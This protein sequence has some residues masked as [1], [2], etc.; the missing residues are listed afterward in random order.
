MLRI[1]KTQMKKEMKGLYPAPVPQRKE[2]FLKE[3]SCSGMG[4]PEIIRVQ[5]GYIHKSVWALS[6]LLVIGALVWGEHF[7]GGGSYD[8]LWCMS[9]VMPLLAV[10]VVTE[11]FRSGIYGMAELEMTARHNLP[12]ILLIRMGAIGGAE[13]FLTVLGIPFVVRQGTLGVF[14]TAVYLMVPWLCT[15]VLTLQIEKYVKGRETVW[16]CAACGFFLWGAGIMSGE[17]REMIYANGKF[18]LWI[19][20]FCVFAAFFA[21]QIWQIRHRT[22][23]WNLYFVLMEE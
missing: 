7:H 15:C 21:K 16:Y 14:R 2:E 6:L 5:V 10:L 23:E 13:F 12:Q 9:G 17:I 18:Y 8:V 11:T 19:M 22:E 20:A 1:L 4:W 3:F